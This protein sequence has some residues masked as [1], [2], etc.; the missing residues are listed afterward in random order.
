[1]ASS[2]RPASESTMARSDPPASFALS[3]TGGTVPA[4]ILSSADFAAPI[5]IDLESLR[6]IGAAVNLV[7]KADRPQCGS[8]DVNADG[9]ADL[10]CHFVTAEVDLQP[11][12][13]AGVLLGRLLSGRQIRGEDTLRVVP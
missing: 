11:G 13:A 5:E 2:S 12:D 7:G 8:E 6:L 4:A 10:V 9:W 3:A 1:M